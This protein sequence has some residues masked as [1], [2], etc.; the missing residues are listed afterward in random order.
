MKCSVYIATSVDGFIAK[1][2]GDIGWLHSSG[3]TEADMS[4]CTDMGFG[5]Y[6]ASVDCMIMG[7]STMDVISSMNLTPEQW[8]YINTRVIVLSRTLKTPPKNLKDLVEIYSGDLLELVAQLESEGLT[9]AYIDGGKTIQSFLDLKLINEMTLTRVPAILGEG[10]PLFGKS[11]QNIK[12][13]NAKAT[14]FANDCIQVHYKV[15]Y[16]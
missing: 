8:P 16:Q 14:A 1:K 6:I 7:R 2:N 12:L 5:E 4:E 9:H 13:E 15:S 3:N 11:I 10:I